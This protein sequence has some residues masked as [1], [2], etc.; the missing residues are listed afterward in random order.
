ML[1]NVADDLAG[2]LARD[3]GMAMPRRMPSSLPEQVTPEVVQSPALSLFARP[4]DGGIRTRRVAI[5]VTDGTDGDAVSTLVTRLNGEGAVGRIVGPRLGAVKTM[6]SAELAVEVTAETT[7]SVLYDAV[8]IAGGKQAAVAMG[9]WGHA[10]EFIQE[11]Y[12]HAKAILALGDAKGTLEAV[13]AFRE[14]PSGDEDPGLVVD[15]GEEIDA[16]IDK[17]VA[18]IAAHRHFERQTDPPMV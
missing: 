14:L 18:A 9:S 3:L 6:Q 11:Q 12:R 16:A 15:A 4:G 8:A 5:L 13:G 2:P 17:F 1:A 10:Q 7:P